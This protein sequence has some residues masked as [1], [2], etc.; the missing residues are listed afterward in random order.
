[1]NCGTSR[2]VSPQGYRL[3]NLDTAE[4]FASGWDIKAGSFMQSSFW[5]HFKAKMGWKAYLLI[6]DYWVSPSPGPVLVLVRNL[7][8]GLKF[9]YVPHGP[10]NISSSRAAAAL[11]GM[12]QAIGASLGPRLAFVRFDLPQD[13]EALPL[14][15]LLYPGSGLRKGR[16]VQVPDTVILDLDKDEN[17][18]LACMKPKWR[19]N[20]RLAA[21]KG[22][23][24]SREDASRLDTFFSLY[25]TTARRD[26]IAIHPLEYYQ[27]LFSLGKE[28]AFFGSEITLWIAHHEGQALASIITLFH[29]GVATYLYGASSD[30]KRNLMPAFALQWEAIKAAKERGCTEYDFFGIPGADNPDDPMAGLYRFKT[31]FGGRVLHRVGSVDYPCRPI[32]YAA[33]EVGEALRL[34]WYKNI[35]KRQAR[36]RRSKAGGESKSEDEA[37][38]S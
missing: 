8:A 31:G 26:G 20:I 17:A 23:N 13:R 19:Y 6:P 21:K 5:G 7:A 14:E 33:F 4:A 10:A 34:F 3:L 2:V 38:S 11:R 27:T 29:H 15:N 37:A 18:L 9:A 30:E 1:M 12:G 16:A 22:V 28:P 32:V 25:Q 35:K 24:I 36:L